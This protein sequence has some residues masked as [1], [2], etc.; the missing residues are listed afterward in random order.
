MVF[1]AQFQ[2]VRIQYLTTFHPRFDEICGLAMWL[3][4]LPILQVEGVVEDI[5]EMFHDFDHQGRF[6]KALRE[7]GYGLV[8]DAARDDQ[9]EVVHVWVDVKCDPVTRPS[10]PSRCVSAHRVST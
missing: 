7:G 3:V 9:F 10:R 8:W 4:E 6:L 5:V 2:P 1:I